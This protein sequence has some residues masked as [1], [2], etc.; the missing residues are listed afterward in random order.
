[1]YARVYACDSFCTKYT[2]GVETDRTGT[3][4]G[5]FELSSF[6]RMSCHSLERGCECTSK[7][8]VKIKN[9]QRFTEKETDVQCR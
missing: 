4:V 9:K 2:N 1:M 6:K 8:N 7:N 5:F 3:H